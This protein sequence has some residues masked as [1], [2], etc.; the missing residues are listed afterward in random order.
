MSP[1][2]FAIE[3]AAVLHETAENDEDPSMAGHRAALK[4]LYARNPA[5]LYGDSDP[6]QLLAVKLGT[7][8]LWAQQHLVPE[9]LRVIILGPSRNAAVRLVREAG[10][11]ALP[12][13]PSAKWEYDRSDDVPVLTGIVHQ[14]IPGT[15]KMSHVYILWPTETYNS[16]DAYAL[17]VLAGV[18]KDRIEHQL[19]EHLHAVY[20]PS[21]EWDSTSTHGYLC[22]AFS[23]LKR[24]EECDRVITRALDVVEEIKNDRSERL[25]EEVEAG[26]FFLANTYL[27]EYRFTPGAFADRMMEALANGDPEL[28]R[29]NRY[30]QDMLRVSP[31]RVRN[32]AKKYLHRDRFVRTVVRPVP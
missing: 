27:E 31:V 11:N 12:A 19:R 13:W 8:K 7:V 4:A 15:G 16:P 20:H 23:T 3:R 9:K 2:A 5:R 21:V 10:L 26:R 29:F 18:M 14:D 28:R 6:E 32:A 25:T 30:Y 17:E 22:L 24:A 1:R